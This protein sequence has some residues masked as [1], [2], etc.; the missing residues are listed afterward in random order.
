MP[1][2]VNLTA[3]FALSLR[4]VLPAF[5][6]IFAGVA[7]RKIVPASGAWFQRGEKVVFYAGM[8]LVLFFSASKI[9]PAS[10]LT[11]T[12]LLAGTLG[13]LLT[14]TAT[15]LYSA[16]R[17]YSLG[18]RGVLAQAS[19]RANQAIIGIALCAN[20][21]GPEGLVAA[22]MPVALWTLLFN[23]IAVLVL[24]QTH[25]G[26]K[27]FVGAIKAIGRNPLI[28]GIAAGFL[29]GQ[30]PWRL[31]L[32]IQS[33]AEHLMHMVIPMALICL[34]G[35]ISL[36]SMQQSRGLLFEATALRLVASPLLAVGFCL[37]LGV[38]G[39][40]LGV[41]F[42]LLGGPVAIASHVMV[43]SVG[44][45]SKVAANIVVFTTLLAPLTLTIGLFLLRVLGL[46]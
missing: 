18:H 1:D 7:C 34:G 29:Y 13:I 24:N 31:P 21:Y 33:G 43:A 20:A 28:L 19:Y 36:G 40:E 39:L 5:G 25:E 35:A 6:W 27:S 15:Y 38:T 12:H 42:L 2:S 3:L 41:V 32:V 9:D 22:A 23:V 30:L 17:P 26:S 45:D 11:S 8:P 4:A 10:V 46:A 16:Y 37:L 44:G 14:V